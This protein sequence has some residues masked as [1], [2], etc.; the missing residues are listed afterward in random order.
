[1]VSNFFLLI[2]FLVCHVTAASTDCPAVMTIA[3]NLNMHLVQPDIWNQLQI[4]CCVASGITCDGNSRV[5]QIVWASLGLNGTVSSLVLP[6]FIAWVGLASNMI[7]GMLPFDWSGWPSSLFYFGIERNLLS[8]SI[9]NSTPGGVSHLSL[10][11][12]L[13]TGLLPSAL[14]VGLNELHVDGNLLSGELPPFP[15]GLKDLLLGYPGNTNRNRFTGTLS[16]VK[17]VWLTINYNWITNIVIVNNSALVVCDLSNTPL[18]GNPILSS[19]GICAKNNLYAASLLPN[20]NTNSK[21]STKLGSLTTIQR[22]DIVG[23]SSFS[24][25]FTLFTQSEISTQIEYL[26]P[27]RGVEIYFVIDLYSIL[28]IVINIMFLGFVFAKTPFKREI[29]NKFKKKKST[30]NLLD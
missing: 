7:S 4:D 9:P 28:K 13:L 12:N 3:R 15:V 25:A 6:P 24:D 23:S 1:M 20:T 29:T 26:R 17:P 30:K 11:Q 2:V 8:S 27:T 10:H 5:Y 19:F 16:V 21:I 18:L 22:L 14:L